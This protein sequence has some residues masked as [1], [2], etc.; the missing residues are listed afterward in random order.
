[1]QLMLRD[2]LLQNVQVHAL[3]NTEGGQNQIC[4]LQM[5]EKQGLGCILNCEEVLA[6][7]QE[8]Q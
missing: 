4:I 6:A 8:I 3:S 2:E 7:A 1:M 5:R